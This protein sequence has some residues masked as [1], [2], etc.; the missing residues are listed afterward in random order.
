MMSSFFIVK[1]ISK[2]LN[3][4]QKIGFFVILIIMIISAFLSQL[5]PLTIGKLTD[6]VL[7]ASE[8]SFLSIIPFL[9]FI[10]FISISNEVLKVVRRLLVENVAT[11]TEKTARLKALK[12]LLKAPLSYF[13]ENMTGNIHGR[14]NRS[15]EATIR[16]I[17]LL[18]MDFAPAI[19][20][21]VAAI[22]VIFNQLPFS[23]AFM[24]LMVVPIGIVIV[25]RQI[26]SQKGIRI[27]LLESKAQM[28]GTTVELMN[29]IEVIRITNNVDWELNRFSDQSEYLRK[30]EMKHHK[31]MAFYDCLK[32]INEAFFTVLILGFSVY[33]VSVHK[34]SVGALLT[35][36][37][38]FTQ[39]INPLKELHRILDEVSE[40][41]VLS[42]EY[43]KIL[44]LK[45]DFSYLPILKQENHSKK[46]PIV[47][48]E[49]SFL[50]NHNSDEL[51]L[52]KLDLN[53][54]SGEF[55]GIAGPSGCGKSTFIKILSKLEE[56]S[57]GNIFIHDKNIKTL[58]REEIA[59]M[60]SLVPQQPFII[61]GTIYDNICYGINKSVTIEDVQNAA[62]RAFI[63]DFIESLDDKYQTILAEGG[64][65]LSGGQRQRIAIAR[66]F[67][68]KPQILILDEATSALD[69]TTEKYI[70][71]E[72]EKLKKENNTIIIS[73]AHRLSTL[74]N[75][76]RI[77]VFQHG[78]IEQT[79]TFQTLVNEEGTFKDMF[80]GNL[81]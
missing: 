79:G 50:Y 78:K 71:R 43:F 13:K 66:I 29:G 35:S 40:S 21:S 3:R 38:C 77:L 74:K 16:L 34:L 49:L 36:Y 22:I 10:L 44:D 69:N 25:L 53:I 23:L 65:N 12:S 5:M 68:R 76:D 30:K 63:D 37:L 9:L 14:L 17:K 19:F 28:D 18:F 70:Q 41:L 73:I 42:N 75:C 2:L 47:I 46:V 72:I 64:S 8:I 61:V 58:N 7:N 24:M 31:S 54:S 27:L 4:K 45:N 57:S 59:D 20:T 1:K 67:L 55:L 80:E 62:K 32:F 26:K 81:K 51:V 15:L 6:S 52:N 48:E 11:Q 33:L 56:A 39:L 60:M